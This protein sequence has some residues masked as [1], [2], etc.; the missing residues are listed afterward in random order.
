MIE[1]G[2]NKGSDIDRGPASRHKACDD[3][4]RLILHMGPCTTHAQIRSKKRGMTDKMCLGYVLEKTPAVNWFFA[5]S[6]GES[7]AG[8]RQPGPEQEVCWG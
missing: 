7:R 6:D 8:C 3:T 2:K 4:H 1:S 5:W